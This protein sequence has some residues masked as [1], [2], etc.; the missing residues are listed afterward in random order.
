MRLMLITLLL[1]S[2]TVL[3][4]FS[5][6]PFELAPSHPNCTV[7]LKI[8]HPVKIKEIGSAYLILD[9]V[10]LISPPDGAYELY[11]SRDKSSL[12][13]LQPTGPAFISVL[14]TYS[15]NSPGA[16]SSIRF[17]ITKRLKTLLEKATPV[18]YVTISFKANRP[19][20]THPADK[21]KHQA[22]N[23][24][25]LLVTSFRIVTSLRS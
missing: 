13:H 4:A 19:A 21:Q 15:L 5:K 20:N 6:G 22:P 8:I 12:A 16:K 18:C 14:D 24:G 2:D 3:I 17:E 9:G 10:R 7:A 25:R 1:L 11:L 23:S